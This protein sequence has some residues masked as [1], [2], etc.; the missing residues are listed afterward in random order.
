MR[1]ITMSI[2]G[3]DPSGGAGVLADIKTFE[4]I[5]VQGFGVCTCITYQR[6]DYLHDVKWLSKEEILQQIDILLEKFEISYCKIG[7]IEN[8]DTLKSIIEYLSAKQIK[9]ILDPVVTSSSGFHFHHQAESFISV[10]EKVYLITPNYKEMK[11]IF[12]PKENPFLMKKILQYT[13]IFLKGGHHPTKRGTDYLFTSELARSFAPRKGLYYDKHGS[14]CILSAALTAYLSLE[15]LL[16]NACFKAKEYTAQALES[17]D[18]L[19][20]Y[21]VF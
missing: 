20:A 15:D 2:A 11:A 8:M 6:D 14:G 7:L 13:A 21:H 9:I 1:P 12:N 17:N 4:T 19:L 18:S 10:L 5:G 3:F 16:P